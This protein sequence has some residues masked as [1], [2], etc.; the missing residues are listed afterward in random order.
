MPQLPLESVRW[1]VTVLP[2]VETPKLSWYVSPLSQ[3]DLVTTDG[4]VLPPRATVIDFEL[5]PE[6]PTSARTQ[7]GGGGGDAISHTNGSEYQQP[8]SFHLPSDT[9]NERQSSLP[10]L[11]GSPP[12]HLTMAPPS[13]RSPTENV[14]PSSHTHTPSLAESVPPTQT[15][16]SPLAAAWMAAFWADEWM[17]ASRMP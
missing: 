15:L 3:F 8:P 14:I 16:E 4:H 7:A 1:V 6:V 5:L 10:Q 9:E 11:F 12:F 13:A 17:E 2:L